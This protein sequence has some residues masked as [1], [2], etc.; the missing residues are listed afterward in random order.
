LAKVVWPIAQETILPPT[1][2]GPNIILPE[3]AP[4]SD[5]MPLHVVGFFAVV[6]VIIR[7]LVVI[8]GV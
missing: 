6:M 2:L 1:V 4:L 5:T 8:V 7:E 3:L